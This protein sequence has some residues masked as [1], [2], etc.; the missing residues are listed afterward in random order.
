[1]YENGPRLRS[2]ITR[3]A[4]RVWS[5]ARCPN[6]FAS[7][8]LRGVTWLRLLIEIRLRYSNSEGAGLVALQA[9]QLLLEGAAC[10]RGSSLLRGLGYNSAQ[11]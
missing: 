1:M 10:V 4:A 8:S 2:R 9:G 3:R 6:S 11:Y 5:K 7:M